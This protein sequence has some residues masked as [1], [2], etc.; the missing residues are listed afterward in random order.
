MPYP[1]DIPTELA[2]DDLPVDPAWDDVPAPLREHAGK[3][4]QVID[5]DE[6]GEATPAVLVVAPELFAHSRRLDED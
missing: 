4:V 2:S 1:D 3:Q 5:L 6:S